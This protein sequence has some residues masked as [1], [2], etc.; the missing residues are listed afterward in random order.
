LAPSWRSR[1][2]DRAQSPVAVRRRRSGSQ[3]GSCGQVSEVRRRSR[4]TAT[5]TDALEVDMPPDHQ[6]YA[7]GRAGGG[8]HARHS[9]TKRPLRPNRARFRIR[10]SRTRSGTLGG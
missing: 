5:S 4:Q 3:L 1:R 6:R 7:G 8:H 10:L 2:T 9:A